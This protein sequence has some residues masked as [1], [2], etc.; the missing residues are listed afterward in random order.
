MNGDLS[1][2]PL[3]EATLQSDLR[4]AFDQYRSRLLDRLEGRWDTSWFLH[5]GHD[6]FMPDYLTLGRFGRKKFHY[7]INRFLSQVSFSH[8]H[9]WI[10]PKLLGEVSQRIQKKFLPPILTAPQSDTQKRFV[11]TY[12]IELDRLLSQPFKEFP[13][14]TFIELFQF[15]FNSLSILKTYIHAPIDTYTPHKK[16]HH[17]FC[18][19]AYNHIAE[20]LLSHPHKEWAMTYLSIRANWIDIVEPRLTPF[21][22][23]FM[24]EI[25]T[26]L[27]EAPSLAA[28]LNVGAPYHFDRFRAVL[29]GSPITILYELDNVGEACF[30]FMLVEQLLHKGHKVV[31]A[32]KDAP[33]LNDITYLEVLQFIADDFPILSD[34]LKKQTLQIIST[35]SSIAGKFMPLAPAPY[36]DAYAKADIVIL[37]GQGNFQ[38]MPIKHYSYGPIR[39][40]KP[41]FFLMG[42]KTPLILDCFRL[43]KILPDLPLIQTPLLYE[44]ASE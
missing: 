10:Q 12:I 2:P 5:T 30:D 44:Y 6:Y 7:V 4:A 3:T 9:T 22:R 41:M 26:I 24:E 40:K 28:T 16:S 42:L 38:T 34:Y 21:L 35:G 23:G 37:K 43:V 19:S 14:S 27:E 18:L 29:E 17:S 20:E 1:H 39:Y 13:Q 15:L 25:N 33:I 11:H 8:W 31:L 32:A 36:R